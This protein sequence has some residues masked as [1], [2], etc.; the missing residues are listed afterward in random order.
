M[1]QE[2]DSSDSGYEEMEHPIHD[3][4]MGPLQILQECWVD[5]CHQAERYQI[6]LVLLQRRIERG[7]ASAAEQH[8][9]ESSAFL[10]R[11]FMILLDPVVSPVVHTIINRVTTF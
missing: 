8:L 6:Y 4:R 3:A 10:I 11:M 5:Y 1:F 9:H 7:E 2:E